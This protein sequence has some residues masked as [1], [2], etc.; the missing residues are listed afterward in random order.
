MTLKLVRDTRANPGSAFSIQPFDKRVL[1]NG[2]TFDFDGFYRTRLVPVFAE[3][4]LELDRADQIYGHGDV[5]DT[6]WHGIQKATLVLVDFTLQ[7]P[8]VS[9]ELVAAAVIG[10]RIIAI[11]QNPDDIPSD[12]AGHLRYIQYGPNY[13]QIDHLMDELRKE[14]PAQLEQPQTEM[15]MVPM[16][17]NGGTATPVPGQ[18][19]HV[20][21]DHVVVLTDD[22]RRVV[23]GPADVDYR[24]IVPDMAKRFPVGTRVQGSFEVDLDGATRYTLLA[25]Q[26]NP[27]PILEHR[28]PAGTAVRGTVDVVV[29]GT[30]AFV[31][32]AQGINGLVPEQKLGGRTVVAGDKVDVEV[33][34]IDATARRIALRLTGVERSSQVAPAAQKQ[35]VPHPEVEVGDVFDSEV[36][37]ARPE[38]KGGFVL[39]KPE[40][41]STPVM[42]HHTSMS[43]QLR[44]DLNKEDIQPGDLLHVEVI[45]LAGGKVYV[46]DRPD[47]DVENDAA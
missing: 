19:T 33:V 45:R 18:V 20:E 21:R 32:V 12:V 14:I 35:D 7:R 25:G 36:V 27:W 24:R 5:K 4:G 46:K 47:L 17:G 23:L 26:T 39:V 43:P 22:G 28:Y 1:P 8:N 13:D 16:P 31:H 29:P 38:G 44:D 15:Y 42:L 34:K 41:W 37:V 3:F 11:T 2:M 40:G 6:A 30:G 10:K 9:A